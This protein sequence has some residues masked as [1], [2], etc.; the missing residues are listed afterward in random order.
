VT[1]VVASLFVVAGA[2]GATRFHYETNL[3]RVFSRDIQS[4]DTARRIQD[5]F[6]VDPGPWFVATPDLA[7]A[8]RVASAFD[9]DPMFGRTESV[10]LLI[11]E[12]L[13]DRE[14][15]LSA[16]APDLAVQ[17]RAREEALAGLDGEAADEVRETLEL[18][19]MLLR[20]DAFGPPTLAELPEGLSERWIG[21]DGEFLV[22]ASAANPSLDS[23]VAA[24]ERPAVETIA[25]GAT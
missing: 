10:A 12:D 2:F 14:A 21:P 24:R 7:V 8:R 9:A 16:I 11:P 20:A 6:D 4:V 17:V 25:P 3:E 22:C 19:G 13:P 5:E 15:R 23:A 18:L 1:V